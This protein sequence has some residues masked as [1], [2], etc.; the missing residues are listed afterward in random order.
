MEHVFLVE[1][2]LTY[3]GENVFGEKLS[4]AKISRQT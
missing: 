4:W 3:L 2:V 1:N